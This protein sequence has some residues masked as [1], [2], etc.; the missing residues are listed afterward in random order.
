MFLIRIWRVGKDGLLGRCSIPASGFKFNFQSLQRESLFLSLSL[1]HS[2]ERDNMKLA[3]ETSKIFDSIYYTR[4]CFDLVKI[5]FLL[6]P[7]MQP[8]IIIF[9]LTKMI[10]IL[11]IIVVQI[12]IY[13]IN[14]LQTKVSTSF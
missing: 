8:K 6:K 5:T 3:I 4:G 7:N 10:Y 14:S 2:G 13:V 11:H 1:S 12:N 9:C